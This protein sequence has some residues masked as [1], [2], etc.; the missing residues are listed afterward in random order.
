MASTTNQLSFAI[1]ER[2][3]DDAKSVNIDGTKLFTMSSDGA[4]QSQEDVTTESQ[5]STRLR[6]IRMLAHVRDSRAP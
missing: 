5:L 6:D 3:G 2:Q 1:R 4:V